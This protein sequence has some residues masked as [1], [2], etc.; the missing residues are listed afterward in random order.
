MSQYLKNQFRPEFY[1]QMLTA[2]IMTRPQMLGETMNHFLSALIAMNKRLTDPI[3]EATLVGF[4]KNNTLKSY[5]RACRGKQITT[6][7]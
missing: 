2:D 3:V 6:I 1:D 7:A 5:R 4:A